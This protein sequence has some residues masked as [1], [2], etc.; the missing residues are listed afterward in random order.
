MLCLEFPRLEVY[1]VL[2]LREFIIQGS[3]TTAYRN[4]LIEPAFTSAEPAYILRPSCAGLSDFNLSFVAGGEYSFSQ[5]LPL[6]S[7]S[8][9]LWCLYSTFEQVLLGIFTL[10]PFRI[11]PWLCMQILHV[12]KQSHCGA[13]MLPRW[14]LWCMQAIKRAI[15]MARSTKFQLVNLLFLHLFIVCLC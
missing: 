7:L 12:W 5:G 3:D 13:A 9:H 1:W 8:T 10:Q 14:T 2:I 11:D 15:L 6:L 4:L